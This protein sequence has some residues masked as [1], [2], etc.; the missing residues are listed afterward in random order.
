MSTT[1]TTTIIIGAGASGGVL[2]ARLSEEPDQHVI[3]VEAGPDYPN[4]STVPPDIADANEMSTEKHDWGLRGYFIE[5]ASDRGLQPYPRGRVVGGSSAVNAAVGVR[6]CVEDFERWAADGNDEWSWD[7]VLPYFERLESDEDFSDAPGH[8][9]SG[10]ITITRPGPDEWAPTARAFVQACVDRGFE[11]APDSNKPGGTGVGGTSRNVRDGVRASALVTYLAEARGRENLKIISDARCKRVLFDGQT[12]TGVELDREGE[13]VTVEG[14]RIVVS[15]GTIHTPQLLTLSG[16]GPAAT[17]E[18]LGISPVVVRE[19]VGQNL[20]DHPLAPVTA[21]IPDTEF[22]GVRTH[23]KYSTE[24]AKRIGL[25]DDVMMYSCVLDPVTLNLDIDTRGKRV[26]TLASVL[27]K[28]LSVGW[29]EIVSTDPAVQPELHFNYL[30][31]ARDMDRMMEAVRFAY[32]LHFNSVMADTVEEVL[33][34]DQES[35]EDDAKLRDWLR[36]VVTCAY[37]A[38]STCRMG[39]ADDPMAVVDQHL[40]VHGAKNLWIA[41]ASV[42]P[43]VPTGLTNLASY[44]IGERLADWLKESSPEPA[45]AATTSE[46]RG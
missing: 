23:L 25:V 2:A 37:H 13:T 3:L 36:Q 38:T 43:S 22:G 1:T 41:D 16:I 44:M 11:A 39:D 34:P 8:G 27:A 31:D 33:I 4:P 21:L 15:C 6:P 24:G 10:P 19:G 42:M 9:G 35:V 14:D 32:D 40:A 18:R 12:A 45:L 7:H 28:P 30:G 17:L 26:H 46:T 20:Q 5:P 29:M